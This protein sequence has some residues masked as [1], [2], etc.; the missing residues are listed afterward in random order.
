[1]SPTQFAAQAATRLCVAGAQRTTRLDHFF[2]ASATAEPVQ[3]AM[4]AALNDTE[5]GKTLNDKT[6]HVFR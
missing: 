1:M 4:L 2:A 3:L 5:D 6:N